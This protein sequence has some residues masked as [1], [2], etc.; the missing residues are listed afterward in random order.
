MNLHALKDYIGQIIY[1]S[2]IEIEELEGCIDCLESRVFNKRVQI[3]VNRGRIETAVDLLDN[4][5]D[6]LATKFGEEE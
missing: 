1:D 5:D 3:M 2:E 4:M 6:V